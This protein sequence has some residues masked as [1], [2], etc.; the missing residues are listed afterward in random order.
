MKSRV[1]NLLFLLTFVGLG[2]YLGKS[3]NQMEHEDSNSTTVTAQTATNTSPKGGATFSTFQE[4]Q[5]NKIPRNLNSTEQATI[6][7]FKNA[8]P[9][10]VFITT[11]ELVQRGYFSRDLAEIPR[12]TGSGF[13]WDNNGHIITNY[14]VVQNGDR[15]QVTLNDQSTWDAE[16]IGAAPEKDLA[17]LKIDAPQRLIKPLPVGNSERLQVGQSTYAIGNPF[18]L[19]QSLTTGIISALGREIESVGDVTIRDVIQT[20]AAINPGNS[21]GPLLNS[22]G[23]LIGVNTA[24]YSPSGAY[25]GI[26]FSI[27]VDAVKWVAPDLIQYSRINRATIGFTPLR[28]QQEVEGVVVYQVLRGTGAERA[29]LQPTLRDRYGRVRLGD[30][31]VGVDEKKIGSYSDLILALEEYQPGDVVEVRLRRER[32]EMTLT[33]ELGSSVE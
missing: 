12:G 23:Q 14:H 4:K 33:I 21:G 5:T 25:A 20:D 17:V 24:I 7:L 11:S 31:I 19:D 32:E 3:S 8:A 28:L 22:S 6:A 1:L 26:G 13:M 2:F 9:S 18:G 15:F 16:L 10:V 27:P 29:G 30:I